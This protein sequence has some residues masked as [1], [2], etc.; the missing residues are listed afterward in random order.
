[1][2]FEKWYKAEGREDL[3][4][5]IENQVLKGDDPRKE[6]RMSFVNE[7][8]MAPNKKTAAE[9]IINEIRKEFK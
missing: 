4:D 6:D 9:N 5:F 1:M 2:A 3:F 7:Y 8:L